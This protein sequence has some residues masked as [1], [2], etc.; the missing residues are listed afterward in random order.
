MFVCIIME[1]SVDL[2]IGSFTPCTPCNGHF[3]NPGQPASSIFVVT[4]N[5]RECLHF[6]GNFTAFERE[7]PMALLTSSG[8][9]PFLS[10]NN[11]CQSSEGTVVGQ[12]TTS[13][14]HKN[15]L[16]TRNMFCGTRYLSH[17]PTITVMFNPR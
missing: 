16:Q 15:I 10:L 9:M 1:K 11:Q 7:F 4:T 13:S 17:C 2:W 12:L 14:L 3:L 6:M 8:S 5:Y